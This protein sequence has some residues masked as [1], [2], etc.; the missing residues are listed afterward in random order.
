MVCS[1]VS[2]IPEEGKISSYE[3]CRCVHRTSR[4]KFQ[5]YSLNEEPTVNISNIQ[6]EWGTNCQQTT[7]IFCKINLNIYTG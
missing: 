3:I 7:K 4:N 5:I 2:E 6:F 1:T